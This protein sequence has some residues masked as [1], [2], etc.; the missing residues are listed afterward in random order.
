MVKIVEI[1]D[2]NLWWKHNKEFEKYDRHLTE[3]KPIFF[4]RKDLD[5]KKENIYILRGCRQV[6]KTTYLKKIIKNLIENGVPSTDIL[7]LSLDFF[8]S[9]RELRN[10]VNYFLDLTHT[11]EKIYLF[12]DEITS[13]EDWNM[14]LKYLSDQG[15]IKRSVIVATGSSPIKLKQKGDLL[16]GRGLEGNEYYLKPLSFREFVL[17]CIDYIPKTTEEF[18]NSLYK[19]K[20]VLSKCYLDWSENLEE[21][22]EKISKIIPYKREL[23]YLFRIYISTGGIPLVINHYLT[24]L[25]KNSDEKIEPSIAEIFIRDIRGDILRLEKQDTVIRQI[26]K[27]IIERYGSRYSFSKIS[28]EIERNHITT[29]SYIETLEDSFILFVLFAYDFTKKDIK[30]KGDKKI[31]FVDPFVF[32]SAKNYLVGKNVWNIIQESLQDE[33]TQSK[34]IEGIVLSHLLMSKE[35]PY[36]RR[37]ETF[38]WNYYDRSGKEIDAVIRTDNI[39]LGIEIKY[40]GSVNEKDI[41]K[42]T[43]I[44]NY[45][46]LSKEDVGKVGNILTVPVDIFISLVSTSE[47]NL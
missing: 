27:A 45:I 6:G 14:E 44:K 43:P 8:T 28:R 16:P 36:I 46:I 25:Y 23:Q 42:I 34:L 17:Q 18:Y 15:I 26:L 32:Y 47:R 39:I 40:Q 37:C 12:L 9:R 4:K 13:I 11:K 2:Q 30:A 10:A 20:S 19:L 38:L 22:Q 24:H 21:I 33:V 5:L 31:Y 35:I 41:L 29:I 1:N 7:Y 3:A